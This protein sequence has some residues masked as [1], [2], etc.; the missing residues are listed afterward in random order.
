[1]KPRLK[2]YR[3][4]IFFTIS[5]FLLYLSAFSALAEQKVKVAFKTDQPYYQFLAESGQ[6]AG[7]HV[8]LMEAIAVEAGLSVEY[9]PMDTLAECLA[10]LEEDEVQIVLGVTD[11]QEGDFI[12]TAAITSEALALVSKK[13]FVQNRSLAEIPAYTMGTEYFST[14]YTIIKST[15]ARRYMIVGSQ[16]ELLR[17]NLKGNAD[18]MLCERN[19]MMYL[20]NEADILELYTILEDNFG[21]ISYTLAVN[22]D[23]VP[24]L[25]K[26]NDALMTLRMSG[27]YERIISAWR[28]K[29]IDPEIARLRHSIRYITW[30]IIAAVVIFSFYTW[31]S[32]KLQRTLQREVQKKT[33]ELNIQMMRLD[34]ESRLRERVIEGSGTGMLLTDREGRISLINSSAKQILGREEDFSSQNIWDFPLLKKIME[35]YGRTEIPPAIENEKITWTSAGGMCRVY[36]CGIFPLYNKEDPDEFLITVN[37]ISREEEQ[38]RA[39]YEREKNSALNYMIAGIAHEIKNPLTGIRNFAELIVSNQTDPQFIEA[40]S[41]LVPKEVDRITRLI[42]NLLQYAR[43]PR[44]ARER[45][46][47]SEITKECASMISAAV[48]GDHISVH[49]ELVPEL[50]MIANQDQIRQTLVNLAMNG[51]NSMMKKQRDSGKEG[52]LHLRF[53]TWILQDYAV[54]SVQDEGEGMTKEEIEKCLTPFYTTGAGGTGLGLSISE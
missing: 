16:K 54:V 42:E 15:Q 14:N 11:Y 6:A 43:P 49:T 1:M 50:Y 39:V 36:N 20:I 46:D 24:M 8:D 31:V 29:T 44:G 48:P 27:N 30:G 19:C 13:E 47:L 53:R 5:F 45:I 51:V 7:M 28:E 2:L 38:R 32:V 25:R 35:P 10:A 22:S 41:R 37:D 3:V 12:P 17:E 33:E 21:T 18:I 34:M 40:F 26:L 9:I 52:I 4:G 23:N